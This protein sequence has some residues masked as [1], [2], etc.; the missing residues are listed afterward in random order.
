M[1]F[2]SLQ[3]QLHTEIVRLD[4]SRADDAIV[5]GVRPEEF[6]MKLS[7]FFKKAFMPEAS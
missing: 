1:V 3:T 2:Y 7:K 6:S 4:L 5:A